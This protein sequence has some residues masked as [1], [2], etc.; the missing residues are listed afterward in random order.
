MHGKEPQGPFNHITMI[1]EDYSQHMILGVSLVWSSTVF[2]SILH[3]LSVVSSLICDL[4]LP[5]PLSPSLGYSFGIQ[6]LWFE[7][8][9]VWWEKLPRTS[10]LTSASSPLPSWLSKRHL[11]LTLLVSTKT[12]TCVPSTPTL[13]QSCPRTSS[14]T[15]TYFKRKI[16]LKSCYP[17]SFLKS[18]YVI[19][20]ELLLKGPSLIALR[21]SSF[22][23]I[24][25]VGTKLSILRPPPWPL[26][27]V[28]LPLLY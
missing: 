28:P 17:C 14:W 7:M 5:G 12:P 10:R 18:L 15:T 16:S 25:T 8:Q 21:K 26:S 2:S 19:H 4:L 1:P 13:S 27:A 6:S 24:V 3:L 11:R 9:G 23:S 22:L 20:S